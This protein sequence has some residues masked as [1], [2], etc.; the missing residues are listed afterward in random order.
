MAS[1]PAGYIRKLRMEA[2]F[3]I[4]SGWFLQ[5]LLLYFRI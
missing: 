2:D 5:P 3:R 4:L 1:F